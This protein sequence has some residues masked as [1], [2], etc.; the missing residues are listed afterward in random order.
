MNS[1]VNK[2]N[3]FLFFISLFILGGT[4]IYLHKIHSEWDFPKNVSL[5]GQAVDKLFN[6][7]FV[8]TVVMF[9]GF[10]AI[11]SFFLL[12]YAAGKNSKASY[13][14]GNNKRT[15]FFM[16]GLGIL[17][18][19]MLEVTSAVIG[20]SFWH[21]LHAPVK[22]NEI[23]LE[24]TGQQ[25]AWTVRYPGK[26]KKFGRTNPSLIDDASG[27][28]LGLDFEDPNAKDDIVL[29]GGEIHVPIHQEI[30]AFIRSKD[31]IHDFFLPNFRLQMYATPGLD[32]KVRFVPVENGQYE[33]VCAQICGLGHY[34]MRGLI[35][36]LSEEDYNKWLEAQEPL[37]VYF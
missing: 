1:Y 14:E 21:K 29:S 10:L 6:S 32:V 36:V 31:V 25:F 30:V 35:T 5:N 37:S 24:V 11:L 18:V 16:V 27:N 26:D 9:V 19:I 20:S 22:G 33:V 23:L 3:A 15:I 8:Q 2:L 28:S 7:L 17:I 13:I 12:K 4:F 34:K